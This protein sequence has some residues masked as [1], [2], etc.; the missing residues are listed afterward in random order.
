MSNIKLHANALEL[1]CNYYEI[2][3]YDPCMDEPQILMSNLY[4]LAELR[5]IRHHLT[6][7]HDQSEYKSLVLGISNFITCISND[8]KNFRALMWDKAAGVE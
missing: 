4:L 8:D 5:Q 7:Y 3:Q 1:L 6:A 2:G